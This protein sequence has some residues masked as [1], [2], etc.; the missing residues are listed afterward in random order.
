MSAYDKIRGNGNAIN[1]DSGIGEHVLIAPKAWFDN[2]SSPQA[3]FT[4]PGDSVTVK[5]AHTFKTPANTNVR[6]TAGTVTLATQVITA[7]AVTNGGNGYGTAPA[8]T[9]SGGGG[10][11]A[12]ATAILVNGVV[13]SILITANGSGYSTAP[14]VSIAAPPASA[15]GFAK[16]DLLPQKNKLGA[17][18]V[19]DLGSNK[20]NWE[21]E[22]V[23][24]GISAALME[25]VEAIMNVPHVILVPDANCDADFYYQLGCDCTSAWVTSDFETGTTKD[26]TKGY[27]CK[28][29][30]DGKARIYKVA[31]D[32]VLLA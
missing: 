16:F 20:Q 30:Y 26:G 25:Q 22:F 27:V 29:M 15:Y 32:P 6:A 4:K 19:G 11:G 2:V 24:G 8:V 18:T 31:A 13:D 14:T 23:M 10:T 12:T 21:L 7:I 5:A 9:I 28:A 1:T 3:P 17:K